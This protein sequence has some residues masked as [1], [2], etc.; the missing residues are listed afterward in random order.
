MYKGLGKVVRIRSVDNV[1]AECVELKET[2]NAKVI[3][4]FDDIFPFKKDWLNEFVEKYPQKVGLPFFTNTRFTVCS[5]EYV[6]NLSL[7]G[8]KTLLIGVEAGNAEVRE[9]ILNR[10]I[11]NKL[12]REKTGLIQ[13]YGIKIYTQNLIGLPHGS[14]AKDLETLKLNID[15]KPDFAGAYLCQPYPKTEIEKMAEEAGILDKAGQIGR[16]FYY[17]SLLKLTDKEKIEKLRIIFSI[18]VNF[19][20]LYNY[21]HLLLKMPGLPL[22]MVSSLLHGYKIK[23]VILCYPMRPKVFLKNLKLFFLRRINSAFYPENK[24][25]G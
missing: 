9:K 4:F 21:V 12:M 18:I 3:H 24:R 20:F 25:F 8:C 14:F 5:E 15:L 23:S 13:K 10:K 17:S 7:A 6:K 19:P 1:V 2:Y 11:S 22:K 16:S